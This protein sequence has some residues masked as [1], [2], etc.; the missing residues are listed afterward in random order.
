MTA[1]LK[2]PAL[3]AKPK[4]FDF[5]GADAPPV[6]TEVA[7]PTFGTMSPEEF[8]ELQAEVFKIQAKLVA[9][10]DITLEEEKIINIWFRERRG[11][12]MS[13][14]KEKPKKAP[15]ARKTPVRKPAKDAASKAIIADIFSDLFT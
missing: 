15:V 14:V 12:A 6:S 9:L 10:E 5:E 1:M 11:V 3:P 13:V 2:Q 8:A 7:P 4:G